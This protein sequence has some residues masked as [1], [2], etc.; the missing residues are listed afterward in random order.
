MS[1]LLE[2]KNKKPIFGLKITLKK[3]ASNKIKKVYIASNCHVKDK[4][5]L[6]SKTSGFELIEVE[7]NSNELG[8]L[9]KMPFSTSIVSF[10]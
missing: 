2:L 9:C 7:Q 5:E 1:L 10:E 3:I 6:M 4:L 8:K